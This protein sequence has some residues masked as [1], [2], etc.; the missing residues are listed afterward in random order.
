MSACAEKKAPTVRDFVAECR[1]R[2][3]ASL[4]YAKSADGSFEV[5]VDDGLEW[6][7]Q[8]RLPHPALGGIE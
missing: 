6:P 7:T 4:E 3:G 2:F 8:P 1:T 5:G